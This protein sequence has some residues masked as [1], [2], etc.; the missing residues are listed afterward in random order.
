MKEKIRELISENR[1]EEAIEILS[2]NDDTI[3]SNQIIALKN[4]WKTLEEDVISGMITSEQYLSRKT[5][6]IKSLLWLVNPNSR[7]ISLVIHELEDLRNENQKLK[8]EVL[9]YSLAVDNYNGYRFNEIYES[10]SSLSLKIWLPEFYEKASPSYEE[11]CLNLE[12]WFRKSIQE[13]LILIRNRDGVDKINQEDLYPCELNF[14]DVLLIL[15]RDLYDWVFISENDFVRFFSLYVDF[16]ILD[17][18]KSKENPNGIWVT[19]TD[20][21]KKFLIELLRRNIQSDW[22]YR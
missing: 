21:G 17:M 2:S 10:F 20:A 8:K 3:D 16:G 6:F 5:K 14:N 19:F 1:V 22:Q 15:R 7:D 18:N 12:I 9:F 4:R 13:L 11:Q